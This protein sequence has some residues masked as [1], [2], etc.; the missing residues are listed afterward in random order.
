MVDVPDGELED[1]I[2][3]S[4]LARQEGRATVE[5][6]IE[7]L[8]DIDEKA[9]QI[10]RG[11]LVLSGILVSAFSIVVDS[12]PT[13]TELLT[14]Y[15]KTG[16]VLLFLGTVLAALT[17]TSTT[18]EI[19]ISKSDIGEI[20]NQDY[21]YQYVEEGLAEQYGE[22]IKHNYAKNVSNALMLILTL[23]ATVGA[24]TYLFIG[25]LDL[26]SG[27]TITFEVNFLVLGFFAIFWKY[28]GLYK[29]IPEWVNE[30]APFS[31]L[32]AWVKLP[33]AWISGND[34]I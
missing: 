27:L 12:Q 23:S 25:V 14:I 20:L 24:I 17:Y 31:R 1:R 13:P 26:Y 7:T 22:Y 6:Q 10:F 34:P 32:V 15:T 21:D 5:K 2:H 3:R 18:E 16:G 11:N 29:A 8:S 4:Q 33:A 30:T 19:G 28:A 9:I